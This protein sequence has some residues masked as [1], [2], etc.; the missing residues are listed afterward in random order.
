MSERDALAKAV[1]GFPVRPDE[2]PQ[3]I[4]P[5]PNRQTSQFPEDPQWEEL[6]FDY[7]KTFEGV[8]IGHSHISRDGGSRAFFLPQYSQLHGLQTQ[9]LVDN[10]F[11]HIHE[12]PSSSLHAVL[13][14][15]IGQLVFEKKWGEQHPLAILGRISSTNHLLYGARNKQEAE[16]LK[17]LLRISYL[18]ASNQW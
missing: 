12:H 2:R 14:S 15:E 4:G 17:T 18:F 7:V 1:K 10:E 6:L 8:E 11:A 3:T 13:P 9:F 5:A 16:Q